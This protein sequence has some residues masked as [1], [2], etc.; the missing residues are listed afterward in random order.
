V[1]PDVLD[2]VF[3][4]VPSFGNLTHGSGSL[5]FV[6]MTCLVAVSGWYS[7]VVLK[8]CS[9]VWWS[10]STLHN[11]RCWLWESLVPDERGEFAVA[12]LVRRQQFAFR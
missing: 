9:V 4:G 11:A 3:A 1:A 12:R 10:S 8:W 6:V 7:V 2:I 5:E